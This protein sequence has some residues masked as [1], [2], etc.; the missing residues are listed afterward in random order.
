MPVSAFR[1]SSYSK[2]Q[3]RK[4]L[5][6]DTAILFGSI[7]YSGFGDLCAG[8]DHV[9]TVHAGLPLLA[10]GSMDWSSGV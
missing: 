2:S 6:R 4:D 10:A 1:D 9:D 5:G 8:T 3:C 7:V